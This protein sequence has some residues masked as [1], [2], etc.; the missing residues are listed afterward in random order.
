V[1]WRWER[2][3]VKDGCYNLL[4]AEQQHVCGWTTQLLDISSGATCIADLDS[5]ALASGNSHA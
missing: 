2:E 4:L 5:G 3:G 1:R